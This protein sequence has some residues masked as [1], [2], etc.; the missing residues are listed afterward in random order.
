M[1]I[2]LKSDQQQDFLDSFSNNSKK[3][4]DL[5][6]VVRVNFLKINWYE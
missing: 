2:N 6:F 3:T 4:L 1:T 5:C